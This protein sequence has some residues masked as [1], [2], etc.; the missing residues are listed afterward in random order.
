VCFPAIDGYFQDPLILPSEADRLSLRKSIFD[1]RIKLITSIKGSKKAIGLHV[2]RG[3]YLTQPTRHPV[4]SKEYIEEAYKQLPYHEY[5]IIMSDDLDW[6]KQNLQFPNSVFVENQ[7][8]NYWDYE[9]IWLLSLCDHFII[10][11]STFSWWGAWLSKTE[12]K[13]VIAPDTWFGPDLQEDTK[14]IYCEDWIKIPT[15]W[16]D[17]YIKLKKNNIQN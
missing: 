17:G 2:R 15:K 12:N 10:S 16:E 5:L 14:D 11:N 3:D 13:K 9:G 8:G 6:C 7:N 1:K 4:V